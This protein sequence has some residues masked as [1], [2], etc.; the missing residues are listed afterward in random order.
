M[1][2]FDR[3]HGRATGDIGAQPAWLDA[4]AFG[5]PAP[6]G[7]TDKQAIAHYR[8]LLQTAPPETIEQAHAAAFGQLPV[9]Q[10]RLVRAELGHEMPVYEWETGLRYGEDPR[11]LA[12]MATRAE[13]E[14]PGTME[15]VLGRIALP[16]QPIG[17]SSTGRFSAR[18]AS[19]LVGSWAATQFFAETAQAAS[20][21][22]EAMSGGSASPAPFDQEVVIDERTALEATDDGSTGSPSW[23]Q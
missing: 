2:L 1:G 19:A 3:F 7:M 20:T 6:E 5:L 21:G 15:R 18:F 17:P 23:P 4:G 9:E 11:S 8:H 22:D 16:E 10:R 13:L 12:R 14:Q